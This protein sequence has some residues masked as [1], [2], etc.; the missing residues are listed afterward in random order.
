[1]SFNMVPYLLFCFI[2]VHDHVTLGI[3]IL[4]CSNI[5]HM[6]IINGFAIFKS[7]Q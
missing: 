3:H 2:Y 5:V 7:S 4:V 1:M 6:N